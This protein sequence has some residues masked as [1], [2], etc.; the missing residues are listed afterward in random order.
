[1]ASIIVLPSTGLLSAAA[2]GHTESAGRSSNQKGI[3]CLARAR[4]L[5][6]VMAIKIYVHNGRADSSVPNQLKRILDVGGSKNARARRVQRVVEFKCDER[7]IFHDEHGA[8][9]S[10]G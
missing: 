9:E 3:D 6:Q 1:M 5:E 10:G 4:T 2:S 7:L 8:P